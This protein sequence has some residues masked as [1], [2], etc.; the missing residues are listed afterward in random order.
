MNRTVTKALGLKTPYEIKE[1]VKPSVKQ[2]RIFGCKAY[3]H[4]PKEKRKKLDEQGIEAIFVGYSETSS[5]YEFYDLKEGIFFTNGSAI[6]DETYFP[7]FEMKDALA[8]EL[9]GR[10]LSQVHDSI[11][12]E[13]ELS[14]KEKLNDFFK[15]Y[16]TQRIAERHPWI[17]VPMGY[18][19]K[20]GPNFGDL[21]GI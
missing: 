21:V 15:Y 13:F 14:R 3:V 5:G 16:I 1:G 19:L 17:P 8:S 6:F 18:D 4:I 11:V 9:G 20:T 2:L 7:A 10:I 12:F